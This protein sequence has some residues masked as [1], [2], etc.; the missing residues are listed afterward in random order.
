[1]FSSSIIYFNQKKKIIKKKKKEQKSG[2][3]HIDFSV[4]RG[5][6]KKELGVVLHAC[7]PNVLKAGA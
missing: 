5:K 3:I 4:L 1:V 6:K 2:S 7:N